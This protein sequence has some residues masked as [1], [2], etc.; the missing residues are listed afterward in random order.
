M[1]AFNIQ[2]YRKLMAAEARAAANG[3]PKQRPDQTVG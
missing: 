2:A 3:R 1:E